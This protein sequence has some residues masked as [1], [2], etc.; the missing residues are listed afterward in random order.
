MLT[1]YAALLWF[2]GLVTTAWPGEAPLGAP[3]STASAYWIEPMKKVHARFTGTKGTFAHFGDSITVSMAFWAP[4]AS[5]PK[6]MS[7]EMTEAHRLVKHYLKPECWNRWK[8]PEFGSNGSMTIRWARDNVDKWLTKLNPEVVL[9]MF[10]SNDVGQMDVAEYEMKTREVVQHCLANG[11][12]VILSTMPPR[13]GHMVKAQQFTEAVRKLARQ[14][15]V[16][17]LDYFS[18]IL[19]RRPDD[20]DGSLPQFKGSPGDEYQVPTLIARDGVHPSNPRQFLG[21]YS[22]V[23]LC[24]N[25][26]GLRNFLTL[27]AYAEVIQKV[28]GAVTN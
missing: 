21:D 18:E 15:Q 3:P 25:G 6:K 20:W 16:P 14:E 5:D 4:L 28:C 22:D 11:T 23:A 24:S 2:G 27:M 7:P 1:P 26:Y 10:G 8:G 12:V 9:V 17:L 19:K 13:S